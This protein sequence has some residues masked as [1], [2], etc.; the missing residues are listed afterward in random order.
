M[1]SFDWVWQFGLYQV[2]VR[3][4]RL[5]SRSCVRT[6][7][8]WARFFTYVIEP[9]GFLMTRRMLL[10]IKQRAEGLPSARAGDPRSHR[11]AAA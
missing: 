11:S 5:V 2:D 10:G 4:T 3:R 9:T 1:S 8:V 7:R 6:Q